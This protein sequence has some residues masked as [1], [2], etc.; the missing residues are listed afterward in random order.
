[1]T[2]FTHQRSSVPLVFIIIIRKRR[3]N[4]LFLCLDAGMS[5]C[6]YTD[7][8]T[9]VYGVFR[10]HQR[11][12]SDCDSVN[13]C[14][15]NWRKTLLICSFYSEFKDWVRLLSLSVFGDSATKSFYPAIFENLV[16]WPQTEIKQKIKLYSETSSTLDI[17]KC[18]D[19]VAIYKFL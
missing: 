2:K 11:C 18:N 3:P 16:F 13:Q 19:S 7:I 15:V 14:W 12:F 8:R 9:C 5:S 6:W 4:W 17:N 1:M 10:W